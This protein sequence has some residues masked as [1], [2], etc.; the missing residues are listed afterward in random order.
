MA[1]F[2]SIVLALILGLVLALFL[3]RFFSR[4]NH[5]NLPNGSMGFP[6]VGETLALLKP[7]SSNSMG[8][9]LQERVSRYG[10]VFKSHLFGSPAIVSCDHD[11][12]MFI[13][14]NEER[15]FEASYPKAM[16]DILGQFSLL[17]ISGDLHRKLRNFV[18][19]F[20]TVSK[21]SPRFLNFAENLA[22]SMLDSW[23]GCKEI[24]FLKDIRKLTLSLMVKSVLSIEPEEP[25][26]LKILDDFR[27]YMK[28]FVSL[29]LNFPGSS[30]SKAVKARTRL[31][32]TMKGIINEREKEKVGLIRGDF[33]DVILSKREILT[34]G[35]IVSVAL[36]I[37]LG[38]YETTSTLIALIVYFLGHVPKA[39]QTLKEEHEAVRKSKQV[40]EPLDLED[41]KKME[42]TKNVIYE[43]MRCGNVVKFLHRKATQDVHYKEYFIPSGWKVIPVL[44]SP[45]LDPSLHESPLKFNPWRWK[46]QET[47]K[48]VMPFGGGPRLCP[49]AELAK[50]EIAFFLHH[51]VLNY[52]WKIRED[53]FPVAYP[54]VEFPRGLLLEVEPAEEE[55]RK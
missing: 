15:L 4:H 27:T 43:S 17:V 55:F 28:G 7:H 25:R 18:V 36:D 32:S 38:G 35:Q 48:K 42:F 13:L 50:V 34:D 16:H 26:A 14:Q 12:N 40:G 39:F 51:L 1:E 6:F 24:D 11:L 23:K 44:S 45:H 31:A 10:K 47:R 37:L 22:I 21:S 20:T 52:R 33:L 19:T 9:F 41:Y 53:E 29:P 30:Y 54:Y 3:L 46:N 5:K 2:S 8:T 49:G